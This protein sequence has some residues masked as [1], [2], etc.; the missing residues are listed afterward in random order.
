MTRR[1]TSV[2]QP[3]PAPKQPM[4]AL[5]DSEVQAWAVSALREIVL[6]PEGDE[7][8][9]QRKLAETRRLWHIVD[10]GKR[11]NPAAG[12]DATDRRSDVYKVVPKSGQA[13]WVKIYAEFR[14][15]QQSNETGVLNYFGEQP[16][17]STG[18]L[19]QHVAHAIDYGPHRDSDGRAKSSRL[20]VIRT[21]DGGPDLALWEQFGIYVLHDRVLPLPFLAHPEAL[22]AVVRR[23]LIALDVLWRHQVVHN[24]IK[25]DNLALAW[26]TGWA[27]RGQ[28]RHGS[29]DL[30]APPLRLLDFELSFC[31]G[32]VR[33]A[34]LPKDNLWASPYARTRSAAAYLQ[35]DEVD[36][37]ATLR[38]VDW[39]SDLWALGD[40]LQGWCARAEAFG[41]AYADA[42]D[43]RFGDAPARHQAVQALYD[44][45]P[46]LAWLKAF[47]QTLKN[48][49]RAANDPNPPKPRPDP[50]HGRLRLA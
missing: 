25:P 14:T 46:G 20:A 7:A 40:A 31:P 34:W 3:G 47:A 43:T 50:P 21:F 35:A 9:E 16:S 38:H 4:Q 30:Q 2:I 15:A 32:R 28:V 8:A 37:Q 11:G 41:R 1:R 36:R 48:H 49:D 6:S 44:L 13:Y 26:P 39:G 33:H 10:Q 5:A 24:D 29:W 23:A 27:A 22:A 45:A 12:E 19:R 18:S 42:F 17:D